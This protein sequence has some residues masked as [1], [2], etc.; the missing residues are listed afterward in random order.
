MKIPIRD[1]NLYLIKDSPS[2]L[3]L[4]YDRNKNNFMSEE[5]MIQ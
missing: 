2:L 1:G 3:L 5:G 4:V